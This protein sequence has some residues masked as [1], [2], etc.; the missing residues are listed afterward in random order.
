MSLN[1]VPN[2]ETVDVLS[3]ATTESVGGTFLKVMAFGG[4]STTWYFEYSATSERD[5]EPGPRGVLHARGH[6]VDDAQ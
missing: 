1:V 6:R 3:C 2:G 5:T 4:R